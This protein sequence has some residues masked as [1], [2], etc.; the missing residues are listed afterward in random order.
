MNVT[1]EQ[2]D[3]G[4]VWRRFAVGDRSALKHKPSLRSVGLDKLI[5]QAGLPDAGLAHRSH[6][7]AVASSCQLQHLT[8]CLDL[9]LAP[10]K[11]G[12][13]TGDRRL[14]TSANGTG[15]DQLEHFHRLCHPLDRHRAQGV[16][17]H[18]SLDKSQ[19]H[20]R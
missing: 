2:V 4:E 10:D 7:L 17:V 8:E 15:P 9:C 16:D 11:P 3:H 12:E 14:Q 6:H 13:S 1:L 5:D 20:P 18:K 19:C